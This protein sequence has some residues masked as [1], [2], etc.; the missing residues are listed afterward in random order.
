MRFRQQLLLGQKSAIKLPQVGAPYIS[1]HAFEILQVW[2]GGTIN[3]VVRR[4]GQ[5]RWYWS[6]Y[7]SGLPARGN[8][9]TANSRWASICGTASSVFPPN[10]ADI[11][12]TRVARRVASHRSNTLYNPACFTR[13]FIPVGTQIQHQIH[14][15][16]CTNRSSGTSHFDIKP[17][18]QQLVRLK[19]SC[20]KWCLT[21]CFSN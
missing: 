16:G 8:R 9:K 20:Y 3:V 21:S 6:C 19:T 17:I 12:V 7:S 5:S 18:C 1:D 14:V 10:L 13:H 4:R 11:I 15:T 2:A